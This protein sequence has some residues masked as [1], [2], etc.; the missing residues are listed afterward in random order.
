M[1]KEKYKPR[2]MLLALILAVL[3]LFTTTLP[4]GLTY[5]D[6]TDKSNVIKDLQKDE[7]FKIKDYPSVEDDYSLHVIAL[8]ESENRKLAVYVYQPAAETRTLKATKIS[9]ST[10][11][12]DNAKWQLYTLTLISQDGV[13]AKYSV[14]NFTVKRDRLR[15]YNISEI[16]RVFDKVIDDAPSDD[17]T[18]NEVAYSVGWRWTA[19]TVENEV[20]FEKEREDFIEITDLHWGYINYPTGFKLKGISCDSH[21]VAF[22]TDRQIDELYEADVVYDWRSYTDNYTFL[23]IYTGTSYGELHERVPITITDEQKA[24]WNKKDP[25]DQNREW[26]RIENVNSFVASEGDNLKAETKEALKSKQWVL[27]F[28][29]TD[30]IQRRGSGVY[31]FNSGVRVTNCTILRLKFRAGEDTY[32]LGVVADIQSGDNKSDGKTDSLLDKILQVLKIIG[33]VL[34]GILVAAFITLVIV[35]I[36]PILTVLGAILKPIGEALLWLITM[37]FAAFKKKE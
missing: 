19:S 32:N 35:F 11:I 17:N 3:C 20:T 10:S 26:D 9:I 5:A 16:F 29:E 30:F 34:L 22:S 28:L 15:Y 27:R 2:Q 1:T 31:S 37:P 4:I 18:T 33:L 36:K 6:E 13:F 25:F 7:N 8:A 14:D 21:Y 24:V 12:G 23:S